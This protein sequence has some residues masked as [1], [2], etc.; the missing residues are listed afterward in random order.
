MGYSYCVDRSPSTEPPTT[1]KGPASSFR[2][3]DAMTRGRYYFHVRAVDGAG[4]WGPTAH[5]ALMHLQPD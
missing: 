4:N 3:T 2:Y 5:Y 1:S